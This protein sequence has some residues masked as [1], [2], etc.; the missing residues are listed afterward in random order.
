MKQPLA[1][2]FTP[3][4]RRALDARALFM[5]GGTIVS[6]LL[7]VVV[8]QFVVPSARGITQKLPR[9]DFSEFLPSGD[10]LS[11]PVLELVD[12]P[13]PSYVVAYRS[14]KTASLGLIVWNRDRA[15]YELGSSVTLSAPDS[16][17]LERVE[18]LTLD[19]TRSVGPVIV[20]RGSTGEMG[21]D[22]TVV[23]SYNS[24]GLSI[25]QLTD[26]DGAKGPAF[27]HT[28]T[29]NVLEQVLFQDVDG[30]GLNEVIAN[31]RQDRVRGLVPTDARVF[32]MRDGEY[33]YEQEL[34]RIFTLS[35]GLFPEPP[36]AVLE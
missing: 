23:V 36:D 19:S 1:R 33:I 10:V 15:A 5:A 31:T 26:E 16:A 34:S 13:Q 11:G 20:A 7:L 22:G 17:Y 25:I 27:F 4:R 14:G 6:L 35:K 30:D 12:L 18:S 28:T 3:R 8:L 32:R 29:E 9:P 24:S 21:L 2:L